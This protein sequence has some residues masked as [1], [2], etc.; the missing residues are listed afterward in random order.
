MH[1]LYANN[2]IVL[3]FAGAVCLFFTFVLPVSGQNRAALIRKVFLDPGSETVLVASHRASHL[4]FP[5]NSIPALRDAVRLGV[6]IIE[7][8]A[9][10]TADGVPIVMHDRT[11][12]RT[13]TGKGDPEKMTWDELKKLSLVV[14]GKPTGER[15]PTLEEALL[16]VKD[17]A[18][19]DL[20]M[21]TDAVEAI[22]EVI[23]K[24]GTEDM[25]FFFDSDRE[26]LSRIRKAGNF[27]VMPRA[28]DKVSTE[29]VIRLYAP[30]VVHID[31][32]FNT[33]D[34]INLIKANRARVWINALGATDQIISEG[35]GIE[36]LKPLLATGVN[37]IQ[38]DQPRL[39]LG[40]LNQLGK[41]P[42]IA[43]VLSGPGSPA[44]AISA[45]RSKISRTSVENTPNAVRRALQLGVDF[46]EIDVRTTKDGHIVILHDGT[47]DRTTRSNGPMKEL[48]LKELQAIK[49]K[50]AGDEKIPTLEEIASIISEWNSKNPKKTALYVD[51]KEAEPVP[52]LAILEKYDLHR[53][54]VFYG[55]DDI[56]GRL[57]S[58]Y[59][60]ARIMP[61]LRSLDELAG[62][63]A[64]LKP[65]A[66]DVNRKI[67]NADVVKQIHGYHI[68]VFTD[69][70]AFH[71][72]GKNYKAARK[73]GV[74]A[75][76]TDRARKAR[77]VFSRR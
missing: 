17:Q 49:L 12:D 64:R 66:F 5:E 7:I 51:C 76:Q 29:E 15:I 30:P 47:L 19:V 10:I 46:I 1:N 54:A 9:K 68:K 62:K 36:V 38:T 44:P 70:L 48:T 16:S 57:R 25:V 20:D 71:D 21:K 73:Q 72:S 6:D 32:S 39:L 40:L 35:Q 42:D 31:P 28:K 77:K 74:D 8:D 75:I 63:A 67:L 56:L 14:N 18:L 61:S 55:S 60:E 13:T 37:V 24:T 45:H 22:L 33:L 34:V 4:K 50:K 41:R 11:I 65:Y 69:L 26:V 3:R 2:S 23:R 52:L 27:L 58:H 53:D 43:P 59:S